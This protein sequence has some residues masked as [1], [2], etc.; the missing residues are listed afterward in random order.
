MNRF[1]YP[2]GI[3]LLSMAGNQWLQTPKFDAMQGTVNEHT[4]ALSTLSDKM[5]RV[6]GSQ[7]FSVLLQES[8]ERAHLSLEQRVAEL[9]NVRVKV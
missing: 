1:I 2:G 7:E 6:V 5:D 3:V 4:A 8:M 9:Q